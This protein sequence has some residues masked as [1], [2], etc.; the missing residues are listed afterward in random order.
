MVSGKAWVSLNLPQ[1]LKTAVEEFA[2]RDGVSLNQFI[3]LSLAERVGAKGAVEYL[4][5]RGAGEMG[6]GGRSGWRGVKARLV[7]RGAT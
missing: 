6:S 1:S 7:R 4:A 2:G 5:A 3:A